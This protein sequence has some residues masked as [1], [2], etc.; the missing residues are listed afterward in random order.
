MSEVEASTGITQSDKLLVYL[1]EIQ[2]NHQTALKVCAKNIKNKN[3]RWQQLP[4][5]SFQKTIL[6]VDTA[7]DGNLNAAMSCKAK[8]I[9]LV[10]KLKSY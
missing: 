7:L 9:H 1:D 8:K 5:N 4:E 2:L 3:T 6:I 10:R